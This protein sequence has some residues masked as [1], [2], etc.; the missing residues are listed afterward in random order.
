LP[1]SW[2]FTVMIRLSSFLNLPRPTLCRQGP[3]FQRVNIVN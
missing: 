2:A 3:K 1:E